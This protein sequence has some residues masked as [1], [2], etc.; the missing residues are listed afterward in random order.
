MIVFAFDRD[1]TVDVNPP[2]GRRAV[3]LQWIRYLAHETEHEVWAI[4]NQRLRAEADIP[5]IEEILREFPSVA[6]SDLTR[7]RRIRLLM[8]LFPGAQEYIVVDDLN[9]KHVDAWTHYFPWEFVDAVE[10]GQLDFDP[11]GVP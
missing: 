6:R 8:D 9:L 3:P 11:P 1:E 10:A 2:A 4:G 7:E 5:G